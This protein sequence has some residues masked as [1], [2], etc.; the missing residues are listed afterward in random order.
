M[1][2]DRGT[3][4]REPDPDSPRG[5][6][7]EEEQTAPQPAAVAAVLALQRSVGNAAVAAHVL[8]RQE[9]GAD[10]DVVPNAINPDERAWRNA[11]E[12]LKTIARI[13]MQAVMRNDIELIKSMWQNFSG[14]RHQLKD[15]A[16]AFPESDIRRARYEEQADLLYNADMRLMSLAIPSHNM[17]SLWADLR[18]A[19]GI[20][21]GPVNNDTNVDFKDELYRNAA[22]EVAKCEREF[23][24][25]RGERPLQRDKVSEQHQ[26]LSLAVSNLDIAVAGLQA[27]DPRKKARQEAEPALGSAQYRFVQLLSP[28]V[29]AADIWNSLRIAADHIDPEAD[30]IPPNPYDEVMAEVPDEAVAAASEEAL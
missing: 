18:N 20:V 28:S 16:V 8:S 24:M 11:V 1:A 6:R 5:G 15:A 12:R 13:M 27:D 26:Q 19:A 9:E 10:G 21:G 23:N 14:C 29:S 7:R 22:W 2:R 17:I 30:P 4:V 25:I 3:R